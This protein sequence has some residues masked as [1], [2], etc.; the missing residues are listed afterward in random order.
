MHTNTQTRLLFLRPA[1]FTEQTS[2]PHHHHWSRPAPQ[3]T[4]RAQPS[5]PG[6]RS[7]TH[8][9]EGGTGRRR[10]TPDCT[11]LTD[12]LARS[13]HKINVKFVAR[14]EQLGKKMFKEHQHEAAGSLLRKTSKSK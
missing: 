7:E 2:A 10:E 14:I 8:R 3:K 1:L 12:L 9:C 13:R 4:G 11:L 6:V 5:G